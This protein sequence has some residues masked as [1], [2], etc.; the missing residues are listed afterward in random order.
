MTTQCFTGP[1]KITLLNKT[2]S[3]SVVSATDP[4]QTIGSFSGTPFKESNPTV[5]LVEIPAGEWCAT[6]PDNWGTPNCN[7]P[8]EPVL[9]FTSTSSGQLTID[10][11]LTQVEICV[12]NEILVQVYQNMD[13]GV[14]T[15]LGAPIP[16]GR[17][18]VA[19]IINTVALPDVCV[20][21]DGTP[22]V[23]TPLV[24]IDAPREAI[25]STVYVDSTG[26]EVIGTIEVTDGCDCKDCT[27]CPEDPE[28]TMQGFGV[29][30]F[31]GSDNSKFN[32]DDSGDMGGNFNAYGDIGT[33][34]WNADDLVAALNSSSANATPPTIPSDVDYSSTVFGIS[35]TNPDFII[36]VSGPTPNI[37]TLSSIP[38]VIPLIT[39]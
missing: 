24:S 9:S 22:T 19:E 37:L 35:P 20:T 4:T 34:N 2:G 6:Y 31:V 12:D 7:C 33:D 23:V 16:T 1:G 30:A 38:A 14:L 36:I 8:V 11:E 3:F 5:G 15:A 18:C 21:V 26:N 27:E 28:P 39:I 25:L 32:L 10:S 17:A 29:A 13:G